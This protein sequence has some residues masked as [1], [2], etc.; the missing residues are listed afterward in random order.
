MPWTPNACSAD[1]TSS[2]LKGLITAV[3]SFMRPTSRAPALR[4][5]VPRRRFGRGYGVFPPGETPG[6]HVTHMFRPWDSSGGRR[7]LAED[8]VDERGWFEGSEVVGPFA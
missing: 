5:S 3:M 2:S 8:R 1:L 6:R 4:P 7:D